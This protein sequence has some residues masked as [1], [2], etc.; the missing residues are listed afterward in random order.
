LLHVSGLALEPSAAETFRLLQQAQRDARTVR[1]SYVDKRRRRSQRTVDPYGFVVSAGRGYLVGFDHSRGAKRV[2]ALDAI[3]E[4]RVGARRFARPT[5]FDIEAFAARSISGIM[6]ADQPTRVTVRFSPVVANA[7]KADRV[8][9]DRTI[10]EHNDG[11]VDISYDV[12]DA[13]EMIRWTLRWGA[14]AEI[15]APPPVRA[16]ARR[17]VAEIAARYAKE[18]EGGSRL[19]ESR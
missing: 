19:L 14:E 18:R 11:S 7:A 17:L 15:I 13:A 2:F 12:D 6:H 4:A 3:S 1:F 16:A 5:D 9:R 10:E 8:V